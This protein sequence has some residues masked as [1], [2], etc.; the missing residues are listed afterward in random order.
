VV[1]DSDIID[2]ALAD[3]ARTQFDEDLGQ[4]AKAG[5]A[6]L[7]Q[8]EADK[9]GEPQPAHGSNV[10]LSKQLG[11]R[12]AEQDEKSGDGHGQAL[13]IHFLWFLLVC[14]TIVRLYIDKYEYIN[15]KKIR[16]ILVAIKSA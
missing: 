12:Q 14:I 3:R 9:E 7:E 2:Y 4:R 5:Q 6:G 11:K 16:A 8:V 10:D 13:C 15:K 1:H